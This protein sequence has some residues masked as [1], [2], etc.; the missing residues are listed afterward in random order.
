MAH[1][2]V[3]SNLIGNAILLTA[4]LANEFCIQ[5]KGEFIIP[6]AD[7]LHLVKDFQVRVSKRIMPVRTQEDLKSEA[8]KY[9]T[10]LLEK[11]KK[12]N[13]HD[14]INE[15]GSNSSTVGVSDS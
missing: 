9:V 5:T 11:S 13:T 4:Q 1:D 10:E 15:Q 12:E 6:E 14:G 2:E 8:T 7:Y 3:I